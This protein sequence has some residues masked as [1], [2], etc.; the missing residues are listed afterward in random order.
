LY[1]IRIYLLRRCHSRSASPHLELTQQPNLSYTPSIIAF[2]V[3][4]GHIAAD[5]RSASAR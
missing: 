2:S 4:L 3:A 5:S 1:L